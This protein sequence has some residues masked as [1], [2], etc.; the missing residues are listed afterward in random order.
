MK[1]GEIWWANLPDPWARRPVLLLARDE[2]YALLT[3]VIVAPLTTAQ[4]NIPTAVVLTPEIDG[5]PRA[6]VAALDN[7]QAIRKSWLDSRI[8]ALSSDRMRE[9]EQAI[10]FALD[11]SF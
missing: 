11:L 7:I 10:H 8:A 2:A 5:V 4:R 3:W 9:V 1:R 6:S